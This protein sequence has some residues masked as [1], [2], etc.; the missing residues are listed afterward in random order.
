M[1]YVIMY[2]RWCDM[3]SKYYKKLDFIRFFS[4]MAILFYHIGI[5]K[6]GYLAVCTFFVLS[7]YL[8]VLSC[9]KKE[10]FSLKDYYLSR[11]KKIYL[12]LLIV[13][14]T[15]IV[16]ITLLNTFDW[17]NLKPE[18]ISVLLGYNNYWQLNANLDYFVRHI[19]SPFMHLWY[20]AILLQF[21][22]VFPIVFITL[23]KLGR[24]VSKLLPCTI[25]LGGALLSY[26]LFSRTLS[27]NVMLAYY[28]TLTRLFSILLGMLLG[29]IHVYYKPL[30]F[31]NK[32][33]KNI[34][35][36]IYTVILIILFFIVDSSSKSW[37]FNSSMLIVT[38]ISMRL[39]S[40]GITIPNVKSDFDK[41]VSGISKISYEV[42]LIQYPVIFIF[43]SIKMNEIIKII[44][45]V[46]ITLILSFIIHHSINIKKNDKY[47]VIKIIMSLLI[48]II[49]FIGIYKF[50]TTK[51]YTGEMKKLEADLEENRKLIEKR[52]KEYAAKKQQE[53]DE[54]EKVLNDLNT[55]EEAVKEAVKNMKIVAI[56]DSIM[57]LAVN[58]LMDQFPNGYFD[59]KVNRRPSQI[60]DIL[61]DLIN[62]N[63]LG[64]VVLFNV[65]T[66]GEF[67]PKY[68]DEVMATLGDRKV[69]WVNATRADYDDF[70][71]RL[72]TL[73]NKYSNV[74]I[75][76][77]VSVANAHPE[78]IVRDG[79]HPSVRGCKAY[80]ETIYTAIYEEYL[81]IFKE[82][83]EKKIKEHE[84]QEKTKKTFIGNDLLLGLYENLQTDFSSDEF[85]IDKDL[86]YKKLISTL[87]EKIEDKSLAYNVVLAFNKK[88]KFT[89]SEY[90]ELIKL[91][92]E[93]KIYVIDV[94]GSISN[95]DGINIIS[96]SNELKKNKD[97]TEFDGVHL[98]DKGNKA[99]T[100]ILK[101]NLNKK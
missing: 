40:Y 32:V 72:T 60:N 86:N 4:C 24:K 46:L 47:K 8:A 6:G 56:G 89:D 91:C 96:F 64:D 75:I 81:K 37:L 63:I 19:S 15:S 50:I 67:Y 85:V 65:G 55:N 80:A 3:K 9:Y 22:V 98:S 73:A 51:D 71:D 100:E 45:I 5:L 30:V 87:K 76:D 16:V 10:K 13:V 44:L 90:K 59:A 14:F 99:L 52:Q 61:V 28:G 94:D 101:D 2:I 97:Y 79:V 93:H 12:P 68:T 66:N 31:K 88:M 74:T 77:W 70:N 7:G 53:K 27:D 49:S 34:L 26:L 95:I 83:R 78:Y 82:E 29:F 38:F 20:I 25:L 1:F 54:W 36:F 17:I 84:E 11:L 41:L 42:Y 23:R 69:F 33:I 48:A 43:Q 18:T 39:I 62:K 58:D 92:K 57:E 21:E 35:F